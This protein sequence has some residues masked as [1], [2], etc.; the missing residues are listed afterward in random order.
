MKLQIRGTLIETQKKTKNSPCLM[1][2]NL[3][4]KQSV[5]EKPNADDDA[6][7]DFVDSPVPHSCIWG[8]NLNAISIQS[9]QYL[10]T[11]SPLQ[12]AAQWPV[13]AT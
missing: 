5:G 7:V 3:I 4:D 11:F 9:F 1:I 12:N 8:G 13:V 2:E 6:G 10:L